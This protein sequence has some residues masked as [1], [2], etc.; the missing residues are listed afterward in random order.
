MFICVDLKG[1]TSN[2]RCIKLLES[3]TSLNFSNVFDSQSL[4][5][6]PICDG[7]NKVEQILICWIVLRLKPYSLKIHWLVLCLSACLY[8]VC[9]YV[10]VPHILPAVNLFIETAAS[11]V[12]SSVDVGQPFIL[13]H[14]LCKAISQTPTRRGMFE[15]T[16]YE[17]MV[18]SEII[19]LM[20]VHIWVDLHV[21]F[22]RFTLLFFMSLLSE[23]AVCICHFKC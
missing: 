17:E 21:L 10:C 2:S 16:V 22:C 23:A 3:V 5:Q 4:Q 12:I 1:R 13:P 19:S 8:A 14:Y 20:F 18:S 7:L 11:S 9:T 6:L 15:Y